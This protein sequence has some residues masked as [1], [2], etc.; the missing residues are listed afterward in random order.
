M[1]H[2]NIP[3]NHCEFWR[4]TGKSTQLYTLNIWLNHQKHV[5]GKWEQGNR[6]L[7]WGGHYGASKEPG[8]RE[9]ARNPQEWPQLRP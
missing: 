5:L 7:D 2:R 6:Y 1:A 3:V 8:S 9:I 4:A